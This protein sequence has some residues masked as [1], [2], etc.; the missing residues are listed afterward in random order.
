M[1][2]LFIS[3][4]Y[5]PFVRGGAEYLGSELVKEMVRQGHEVSVFTSVPWDVLHGLV[6]DKRQ[7]GKVLVYRFWPINL[8]HY[9]NAVKH[10]WPI[11]LIWQFVNL[12]NYY[13]SHRLRQVMREVRPELVVSFNL[14]GLGFNLSKTIK[15]FGLNHIH[16]LH[17]IQLLHP[18]GLMM[19]GK[20][21]VIKSWFSKIYQTINKHFW[22]SS[23]IILAPSDWLMSL[24]KQFGFFKNAVTEVLPNPVLD[25]NESTCKKN[26]SGKLLITYVGQIEPHKGIYWLIET[27]KKLP[28]DLKNF[29]TFEIIPTG[30]NYDVDKYRVAVSDCEIIKT[31][32]NQFQTE[33]DKAVVR[34]N[35][36]VV[37][38]FCYE[39]AP[40]AITKA[41]RA[42][43]CV[44]ASR[45][46]G[47]PELVKEGEN[48]WLF[49]PGNLE[50]FISKLKI[51]VSKH[52]NLAK[53][54][55]L[56]KSS[57]S[58]NILSNYIKN[59]INL[60]KVKSEQ[61]ELLK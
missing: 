56:A 50:E 9:L 32:F 40:V 60:H 53:I 23:A 30:Q 11:R 51:I 20:E 17:D 2:I 25:E 58:A 35:L 38:S 6:L 24:H 61:K 49:E 59:I 33:I 21:N 42:G 45:I 55:E 46:G 16:V 54:S 34:S 7:E 37:P 43:T 13:S 47:I 15:S 52:E 4:L 36:V 26:Q 5:P 19:W 12:F 8:Y 39:N 44:L 1:K 27:I 10:S 14:M 48:G 3:N 18:S 22:P 28:V 41:L 29:L 31:K 57:V